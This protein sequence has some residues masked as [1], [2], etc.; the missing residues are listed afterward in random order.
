MQDSWPSLLSAVADPFCMLVSVYMFT[1]CMYLNKHI[2]NTHI[3]IYIHHVCSILI[4][5]TGGFP[6]FLV[7]LSQAAAP[8][9]ELRCWLRRTCRP[10][11][12]SKDWEQWNAAIAPKEQQLVTRPKGRTPGGP[13]VTLVGAPIGPL[14]DQKHEGS[15]SEGLLGM[16][17]PF[18]YL[19]VDDVWDLWEVISLHHRFA[20]E[21]KPWANRCAAREWFIGDVWWRTTLITRGNVQKIASRWCLGVQAMLVILNIEHCTHIDKCWTGLALMTH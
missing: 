10:I 11:A 13:W 9:K 4:L 15:G 17:W 1:N 12:R 6:G 3:Y 19:A 18:F 16:F 21:P 7:V 14:L 8:K 20:S 5:P 2:H